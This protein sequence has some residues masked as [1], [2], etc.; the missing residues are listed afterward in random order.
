MNNSIMRNLFFTLFLPLL[1]FAAISQLDTLFWFVAP[2]ATSAHG[3][4]PIV[5]R[6]ATLGNPAT[7]TVSQPANPAFPVQTL[8]LA[9]NTAQTLDVTPWIASIENRPAN[10]VLNFGFKVTSTSLIT[11]YYE[12]TPTCNCNP[13]IMAMKGKNALGT[14]FYIG[15]QTFY[16]NGNYNPPARSKFDIVAT[17]NN[18][19]ITIIPRNAITGNAANVSYTIT[20]NAGQTYSGVATGGNANQK[21]VGSVI[22]SNKP[23]AV[24]YSDDSVIMD[25]C[26]DILADQLI[27]T[28]IVGDEYIVIRGFLNGGDRAFVT[29]IQNGTQV[30]VNGNPT[31]VATINAGQTHMIPVTDPS[32]YIT[33]SNNTY[34]F[35]TSGFGCEVGGA[36]LPPIVCTGSNV[37]PF[38]RSTTEFF[39]MIILVPSG[40]ETSFTLNGNPAT[41]NPAD[42]NF[43]PGTGNS[44]KFARIDM[45]NIITANDAS[46]LENQAVKFHMGIINGGSSSGCRYGY[47]SDFS[48]LRYEIEAD[49]TTICQGGTVTLTTPTLPGATYTWFG[50]NGFQSQGQTLTINNI[51]VSQAGQYIVDGTAPGACELIPDTVT[52]TVLEAGEAPLITSNGPTCHNVPLVFSYQAPAGSIYNWTVNNTT[53]STQSSVSFNNPG[54]YTV[55]LITTASNG[56]VSLPGTLSSTIFSPP[57]VDYQGVS[58]VCGNFVNFQSQVQ[59]DPQ[60]PQS[61]INWLRMPSGTLIG[62]G[63]GQTGVQATNEPNS[64][65][66]FV[67]QLVTQNQCTA[68]DTFNI[69]FHPFPTA[70]FTYNDLCDGQNIQFTNGST[71]FGT[72]SAGDQMNYLWNFGGTNTS[73]QTNPSF[74]FSQPGTYNVTLNIQTTNGCQDSETLPIIVGNVPTASLAY[75]EECGQTVNFAGV[76]SSGNLNLTNSTWSIPG[77]FSNNGLTFTHV[78]ANGGDYL[79]TLNVSADNGCS[80]SFEL[81]ITVT[82]KVELPELAVPNVITVNGDNINEELRINPIFE[83]CFTYEINIFNRW[84]H[85]V[86]RMTSSQDAFKGE[87]AKGNELVEGVY[88]YHLKSDQGEKHGFIHVIKSE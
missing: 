62:T 76:L 50:P 14:N 67:V 84:G 17:E 86:Y 42:F 82:P 46:R 32:M 26:R 47:F 61:V 53:V 79:S 29:A 85:L 40:G 78:F 56:C 19:T 20:L 13:D 58:Q 15:G 80:F 31:A 69:T 37:V 28:N 70:I 22:T 39:G 2:E 34:V 51:Q 9:A 41:I 45:S 12:I 52:I 25:G 7:I 10:Q 55:Q 68:T 77:I 65:E 64:V 23:I 43:V 44:W 72:P 75:T 11:A 6:F 57:T 27:P 54:N 71:W 74:N 66:T 88:F 73:N 1:S 60:D 21:V 24:T 83:N 63:F 59:T 4:N 87:D 5:F 8:N 18:T 38:V 16:A 36:L 48:A 30:F 3:D 33:T 81:P 35:H 49:N